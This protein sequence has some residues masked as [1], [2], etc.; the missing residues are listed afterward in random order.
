MTGRN[1][2]ELF[3]LDEAVA[4][5]A[6]HR[7]CGYCRRAAYAA[8][9]DCWTAKTRTRPKAPQMDKALHRHRII[10]RTRAQQRYFAP[11]ANLPDGTY[12]LWRSTPYLVS[13]DALYGY[14]PGGYAPPIDRPKGADVPVMTP[15]PTVDVLQAGY[16]A[17]IHPSAG[18]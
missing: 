3:F 15:K 12:I 14:T 10:P 6:G 7:P 9:V 5:A 11:I 1:W 17:M 2:T 4:L 18:L 8:F 16:R 13:G